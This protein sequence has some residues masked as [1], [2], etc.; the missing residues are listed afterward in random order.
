MCILTNT[1]LYLDT[2]CMIYAIKM[3]VTVEEI[4]KSKDRKANR[5]KYRTNHWYLT[6][7]IELVISHFS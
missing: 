2:E 5:I 4:P 6:L 1:N 3:G 7:S